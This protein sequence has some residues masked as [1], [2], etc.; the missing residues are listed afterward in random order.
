MFHHRAAAIVK[1]TYINTLIDFTSLPMFKRLFE[2]LK[3]TREKLAGAIRSVIPL[4][5][6]LSRED[7]SK[8][9][10]ILIGADVGVE[11]TDEIVSELNERIRSG[12]L[13]GKDALNILERHLLEILG[14]P[15]PL[16]ITQKPHIILIVGVNGTGKTTTIGKLAYKLRREGKKVLVAAGD[17]FRAAAT[18]Q[19]AIWAQ[20]AEIEMI[21]GQDGADPASVVFDAAQ[22][23]SAKEFDVLIA[24][25][26]GRLHTKKNLMEE[27]KKI[28][29]VCGKAV[30]G[31]PHDTL[32]I[33]DAT[34]G[35]NGLSQ[36]EV[37]HDAIPLTGIILAKLDGTA[38]GGI[39]VAIRRKLGTPIRAIGIGEKIE[40]LEDFLP[41]DY[42]NGMLEESS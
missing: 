4:G 9:E 34:T 33:I 1:F 24:D 32:L 30:P 23:A 10:E 19:L 35:Q 28:A 17:T 21:H 8:L 11:T 37:F 16:V 6:K 13:L 20:R 14:K 39:A 7:I 26:A 3:N 41:E 15:A 31:A 42:V 12:E 18:D 22:K 36:A 2:S 5:K 40:D 38:K 27:L 25:T 29:R